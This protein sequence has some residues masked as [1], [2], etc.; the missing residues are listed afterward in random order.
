MKQLLLVAA[1]VLSAASCTKNYYPS[2]TAP[3]PTPPTPPP[4]VV[5]TLEFRVE[6]VLAFNTQ[7]ADITYGSNVDGTNAV[8]TGLPW[9]VSLPTLNLNNAFVFLQAVGA[10]SEV[11]VQILVDGRVFREA[12]GFS[13]SVSGTV[14]F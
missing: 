6:S 10:G 14:R 12:T 1:L 3:D 2:P 13:P 8:R 7:D 4:A 5:H 9:F 11:R